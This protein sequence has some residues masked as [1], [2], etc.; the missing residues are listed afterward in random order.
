[1]IRHAHRCPKLGLASWIHETSLGEEVIT[2]SVH[3]VVDGHV[4]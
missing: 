3:V 1:M 2:I 4:Q